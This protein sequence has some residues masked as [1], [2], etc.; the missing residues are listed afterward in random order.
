MGPNDPGP[1]FEDHPAADPYPYIY[2]ARPFPTE[3]YTD[4]V[5]DGDS[6]WLQLDLGFFLWMVEKVRLDG[7]D[8]A[9]LYFAEGEDERAR[10]E[11]Q[12]EFVAEWYREG[13]EM[14]D[15]GADYVRKDFP[16]EVGITQYNHT[17][18]YGRVLAY[19]RRKADGEVL[20]DRLIEEYPEAEA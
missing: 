11:T 3:R 16:F 13:A 10:A 8:T 1:P 4:G 15:E 19:V 18:K 17:G 2:D 12:R 14:H 6:Q 20:N 9:E 5:I 7:V